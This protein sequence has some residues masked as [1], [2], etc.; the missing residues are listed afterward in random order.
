MATKLR[1]KNILITIIRRTFILCGVLLV[2]VPF[3]YFISVSFQP[4]NFVQGQAPT[5]IFKPTLENYEKVFS[6]MKFMQFFRNSI[7]IC[8]ISTLLSVFLGALAAYGLSRLKNKLSDTI[9]FWI[10]TQRMLPAIAVLIPIYLVMSKIRMLDTYHGLIIVYMVINLPYAVW[11]SRSF[12]DDI[13]LELDESAMIDGCNKM[14]IISKV[15]F[16]IAKPGIL[17][18]GIFIFV[19]SWSEFIFALI[20]S[21]MTTKTLPVAISSFISD[22][23]IEWNSMAAAGAILIVPLSIMFFF[24]QN[25][26]VKGLSFGAVKG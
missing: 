25:S 24:I 23:G 3:F 19:L 14:Q 9:S 7:I 2:L 22:T 13:P 26:L 20:L 4:R 5:L 18:T 1:G 12:I 16:P 11:M 6:T 21:S 10:L 15:I 17:S 8:S